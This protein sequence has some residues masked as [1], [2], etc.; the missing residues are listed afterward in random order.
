MCGMNKKLLKKT[1]KKLFHLAGIKI[2]LRGKNEVPEQNK[3]KWLTELKIKTV[4]DIG[5]SKGNAALYFHKLFPE[6]QIFSF[7]PLKD[8]FEIMVE[9]TKHLPNFKSF[10]VALSDQIGAGTIH[11]SSYSGSS[12]LR[13]M[14]D[15]HKTAFPYTAGQREETV[16]IE[17]LDNIMRSEKLEEDIF[18]KM[19]VQG[20]EDKIILGGIE[21]IKRAKIILI[22]TSFKELYKGQPLFGEIFNLLS[23]LGFKYAGAPDGDLKNPLDGASL[24]QDSVFLK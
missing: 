24:Q 14:A 16:N 23:G 4:L 22:E 19:D 13:E 7:E 21:T 5:A 15:L 6:A 12:S 18:V 20:F 1:I 10:N 11:R 3:L 8:C 9:K 17:T 2:S